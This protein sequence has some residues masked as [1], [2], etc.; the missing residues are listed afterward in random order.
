MVILAIVAY[1]ASDLIAQTYLSYNQVNTIHRA[2]LKVESALN[3]ITNRLE[4]AIDGTIVKRKSATNNAIE[5]IDNAPSDYNVLEWVGNAVDSFEAHPKVTGIS[6]A[7]IDKPAW[8]G[9]CNIE[10]STKNKIVTPGSNLSF[11]QTIMK[12][13]SAGKVTFRSGSVALFFPGNY[14]YKNIGY[15]GGDKSGVGRV[16]TFRQTTSTLYLLNNLPR[17]TEHYKLSWSA[18]AVVPTH[19]DANGVCDLELRYNFRPWHGE[20]YDSTNTPSALLAKN[21]TVFK[22]YATQNRVHIKLC[23]QER[24]GANKKTS[25]CKEKVVFQ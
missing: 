5:S 4:N 15:K 1:F 7:T 11:A 13:L 12:N 3:S 23:V 20:D 14:D 24:F 2:N 19:C 21:V 8:S 25:V 10:A 9:F 17:V 22:T 18:Y 6:L 16:Y